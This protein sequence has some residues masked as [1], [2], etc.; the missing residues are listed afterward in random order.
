MGDVIDP[1]HVRD[2]LMRAIDRVEINGKAACVEAIA[3]PGN[4]PLSRDAPPADLVELLL[5]PL[6]PACLTDAEPKPS[7]IAGV[8]P[9]VRGP[10]H[11][12]MELREEVQVGVVDDLFFRGEAY[13]DVGKVTTSLSSHAHR[14]NSSFVSASFRH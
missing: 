2:I 8:V 5:P 10:L 6:R 9:L 14:S 1:R 4:F 11:I 13:K 12:L 3:R 7:L